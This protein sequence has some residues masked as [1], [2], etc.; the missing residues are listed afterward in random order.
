M[1][2]LVFGMSGKITGGIE[3]FLLNMNRHM[4]RDCVFDY[5][6][7]E[8]D[9]VH[10]E[11][12]EANG[13]KAICITPYRKSVIKNIAGLFRVLKE[14][15]NDHPIAYFNLFSMAHMAPVL[16]ARMMGYKIVLH[17]HNSNLQQK[18]TLY[19]WIHIVNRWLFSRLKCL[20]LTN[21]QESAEFM[22]G[23][24]QPA[25][26]IYNAIEIE[27]FQFDP[28]VRNVVRKQLGLNGKLVFGF[29][30]RLS[31]PK[32]PFF[33]ID[34][35]ESIHAQ[36]RESILLIA[37]EGELRSEIEARIVQ[38]GLSASV[39]LLGMR[40]DINRIYQAMDCFILPSRFEGLGIVLIEAQCAGLPCVTSAG[41]V[42]Q[43][44]KV[45]DLV[46]FVSLNDSAKTWGEVCTGLLNR[47]VIQ[48]R[49]YT[50]L[51]RSSNFNIEIEAVRL[52]EIL[53]VFSN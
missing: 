50:E 35:F 44:A 34:I 40:S 21:S 10:R 42:P 46:E 16:L 28:V 7:M 37:G 43:L 41:V 22:F 11:K 36:R 25:Q 24:R 13:G 45:T 53:N 38:K 27:R 18:S 3:T 2:V 39:I 9:S 1:R 17:A 51:L 12:I 30:G 48:R 8:L 31:S 47:R 19:R 29:S 5:V 33:L 15:K 4:S 6:F 14:N 52:E 20:R 23:S 49:E 26:L 32:N